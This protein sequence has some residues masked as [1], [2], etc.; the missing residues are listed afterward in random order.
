MCVARRRTPLRCCI[1]TILVPCVMHVVT[2]HVTATVQ[3]MAVIVP[4]Q[5]FLVISIDKSLPGVLVL[6]LKGGIDVF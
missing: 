1:S 6:S 2:Q 5:V 4:I 3:L